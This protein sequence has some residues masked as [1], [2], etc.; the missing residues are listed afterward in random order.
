MSRP[1]PQ[2]VKPMHIFTEP[3]QKLDLKIQGLYRPCPT[4]WENLIFPPWTN[5]GPTFDLENHNQGSHVDDL[6]T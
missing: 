1:C 6:K 3:G 2:S 4:V 5:C